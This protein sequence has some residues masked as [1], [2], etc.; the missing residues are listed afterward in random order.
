MVNALTPK[1][2]AEKRAGFHELFFDLIFVYAIQ[3]I[4]HVILTTQNGS[5]SADLFFKYIVMS[6]FLWL[7]WSHQTFF[8]N[9]FGQVTFKDVSFMMFNMF[10]MVFLSN[11]LYP[12]FEKTFFPFFLCVAIMYLSIGL[13]YLL[14]IRTG[15][16]YGDKRTCQAFAT[17]AFVISFLSFLSLVLP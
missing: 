17:V 8:T 16:D 7:M 15:L 3:K 10:I 4:A 5:I 12:D 11:S 1:H 9:R 14:H 13:Q 2:L 6:L